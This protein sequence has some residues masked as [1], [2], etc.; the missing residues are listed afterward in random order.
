M[1]SSDLPFHVVNPLPNIKLKNSL[2]KYVSQNT[3]VKE[4]CDFIKLNFDCYDGLKYDL[5]F[6]EYILTLIKN[7]I[8]TKKQKKEIDKKDIVVK[9]FQNLFGW[10]E[11]S[12]TSKLHNQIDYLVN[13]K[14][15][16]KMKFS[17]KVIKYIKKNFL[18]NII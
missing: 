14:I 3:I 10:L 1:S 15:I 2:E 11:E 18:P 12:D 7:V 17:K 8:K 9:I 4:I 13:N 16:K 6:L 5:E